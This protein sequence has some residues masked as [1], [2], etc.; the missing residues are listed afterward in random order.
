MDKLF[1]NGILTYSDI[2]V[3]HIVSLVITL[4]IVITITIM[5]IDSSQYE[6]IYRT[7]FIN[8]VFASQLPLL[9]SR[10]TSPKS[11]YKR[12]KYS[13]ILILLM[14]ILFSLTK[15]PLT[16]QEG[17]KAVKLECDF[18]YDYIDKAVEDGYSRI[19]ITGKP[20][21]IFIGD[22]LYYY[23]VKTEKE[24]LYYVVDP[25]TGNVDAFKRVGL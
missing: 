6:G 18:T 20:G 22:Y 16:Y 14:P 4:M 9:L 24:V 13:I 12:I 15:P 25:F 11:L 17:M 1:R 8:A 23:K 19:P 5:N 7:S 21:S 3:R 10:K 2:K